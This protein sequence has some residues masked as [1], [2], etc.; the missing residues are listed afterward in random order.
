MRSCL[1]RASAACTRACCEASSGRPVKPIGMRVSTDT[2][3]AISVTR[4]FGGSSGLTVA[5]GSRR[6]TRVRSGAGQPP[7]LPG[8]GDRILE[9]GEQGP[10]AV[11]IRWLGDANA[12]HIDRL[13]KRKGFFDHVSRGSQTSSRLLHVEVGNGRRQ[14]GF[15]SGSLHVDRSGPEYLPGRERRRI[16]TRENFFAGAGLT[17]RVSAADALERT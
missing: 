13:A 1:I 8:R 10:G 6:N 12:L 5:V 2:C 7:L 14:Q 16:D 17:A 3:G 15:V 11:Q 4:R 9:A